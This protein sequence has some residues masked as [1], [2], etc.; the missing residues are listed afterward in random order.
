MNSPA[1]IAVYAGTFD[2]VTYGHLSILERALPLFDQVHWLV[3]VN[4]N[5]VPWFT[6]SERTE[7]LRQCAPPSIVVASTEGYVVEYARAVGAQWLIRGVRDGADAT[8]ELDLAALNAQLAPEVS[9]L[10][11]T[12]DA[13]TFEL[14]SSR[15]KARFCRGE[16]VDDWCPPSVLE[17]LQRR[18]TLAKPNLPA[19]HR[20]D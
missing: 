2:P 6:A 3:A 10:F 4:P 7:L 12:A 20:V 18:K 17:A 19:H 1:R 15:L 14:S 5:K 8:H 13:R 16:S 9:S 11:I